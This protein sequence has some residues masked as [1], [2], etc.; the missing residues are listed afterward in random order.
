MV[1]VPKNLF[2]GAGKLLQTRLRALLKVVHDELPINT[3][4][5]GGYNKK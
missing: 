1:L 4:E 2:L 3:Y 5:T